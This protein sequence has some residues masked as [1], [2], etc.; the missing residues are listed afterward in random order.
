MAKDHPNGHRPP[1][2]RCTKLQVHL[3]KMKLRVIRYVQDTVLRR[4]HVQ[5]GTASSGIDSRGVQLCHLAAARSR[6]ISAG[7]QGAVPKFV[8]CSEKQLDLSSPLQNRRIFSLAGVPCAGYFINVNC[9]TT[10]QRVSVP[11]IR[12]HQKLVRVRGSE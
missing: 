4:R 2:L 11:R 1:G 8:P 5:A 10:W 7:R 12:H 3:S 6:W 9:S